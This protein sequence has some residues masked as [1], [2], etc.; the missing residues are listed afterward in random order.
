MDEHKIEVTVL[1]AAGLFV[2]IL[3]FAAIS[4]NSGPAGAFIANVGIGNVIGSAVIILLSIYAIF[5]FRKKKE[6]GGGLARI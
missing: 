3:Y 2:T 6:E 5:S 1:V 4:D